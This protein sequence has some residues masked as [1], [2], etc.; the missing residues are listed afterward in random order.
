M[1]VPCA[2]IAG[3]GVV[4]ADGVEEGADGRRGCDGCREHPPLS[5]HL[6]GG[7]G[8]RVWGLG[9][10]VW[11]WGSGVWGLGSGVGLRSG[12]WGCRFGV[13]SK[14]QGS[15]SR[16]P[17]RSGGAYHPPWCLVWGLGFRFQDLG[18]RGL[19]AGVGEGLWF[20]V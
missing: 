13:D 1:R 11:G 8:L 15:E 2:R 18:F 17:K 7:L 10:G 19:V 5:R 9:F 14:V 12:V 4:E 6:L 16:L 3:R 20:R